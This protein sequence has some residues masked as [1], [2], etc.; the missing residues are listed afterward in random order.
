M[1][2]L[3]QS[4]LMVLL[5]AATLSALAQEQAFTNR[6]TELKE[7]GDEG[8]RT[9][10]SLPENT[11]LKVL[12]RAGA[13]T[14]VEAG[15]QAGFVRMFHLRFPA[16]VEGASSSSGNAFSAIG[17][18]ISGQKGNKQ[19]NLATTGVRG[20]SQ[21]DVKNAAPDAAALA[22]MQSYR[23]DRGAAERFAREGRLAEAKVED[24][25]AKGGR[26]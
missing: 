14:R 4:L 2:T 22:K 24:P 9:L 23:A 17:G 8:A 20:I 18:F 11:P 3:L 19:A 13:W 5:L 10:T 6:A 26:R 12:A 25:E 21:D 15:G 1:K 16:A 7:R